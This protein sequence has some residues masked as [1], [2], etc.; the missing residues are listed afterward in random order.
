[1]TD[2]NQTAQPA[3]EQEP[4]R[5]K[6]RRRGRGL[7]LAAIVLAAGLTGA[8]VT[9]A[10]S[11]PHLFGHGWHGGFMG[12]P[13]TAARIEERADKMVR[14]LAV[15][16][17]ATAEQQEKLRGVVKSAL[18]E[19]LPAR[20]QAWAARIKARELLSQPKIDRAEIERLRTEQIALADRVS[21]RLSQALLD[22]AETLT[23]EQ[24][25]KLNDRFPPLGGYWRGW[26]HG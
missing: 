7:F 9:K 18:G 3:D 22:A 15:E 10:V 11:G 16:I 20:E 17:D 8:A 26:R 1:M 12:A 6:C 19:V 21:K 13:M 24:R 2:T 5:P 23:P 14:H 25:K 4:Q